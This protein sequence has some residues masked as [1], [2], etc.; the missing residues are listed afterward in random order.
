MYEWDL[1]TFARASECVLKS[2]NYTSAVLSPDNEAV[3]AVGSDR[4]LKEIRG[5]EVALEAKAGNEVVPDAVLTQLVLGANGRILIAG[6][7]HGVVRSYKL[8]LT[9]PAEWT[10]LNA[11]DGAITRMRLSPDHSQLFTTGEDGCLFIYSVTD[12]VSPPPP[13]PWETS[14]ALTGFHGRRD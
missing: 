2:C 6:T 7:G 12:K 9:E 4:T 14:P 5:G 1:S 3:F 13:L 8:P 10:N 11:H